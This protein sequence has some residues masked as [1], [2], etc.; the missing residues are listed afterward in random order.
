M[1]RAALVLVGAYLC[2]VGSIVHRHSSYAWGVH[3][4]WGLALAIGGTL[5]VALAAGQLVPTGA[6]WLGLGWAVVL[7]ALQS[8]PGNSYLVA[9]DWLGVS[10]TAGSLGGIVVGALR[11]P[12]V[13]R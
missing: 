11:A 3:W 9:A 4:P 5:A 12:R 8:P 2:L 7:M 1:K 6:A 10:F 13:V